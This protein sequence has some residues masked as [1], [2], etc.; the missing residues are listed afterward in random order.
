VDSPV[1]VVEV[2]AYDPRWPDLFET[3]RRQSVD[4]LPN[5]LSIEHVG[6]TSVS[7]LAAKPIV[8]IVAWCPRSGRLLRTSRR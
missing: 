7:G 3:E 2:V 6:S 1:P 5:A 8:D 4:V